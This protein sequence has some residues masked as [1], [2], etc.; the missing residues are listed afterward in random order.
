MINA[1]D[2]DT[3]SKHALTALAAHL[4]GP[5]PMVSAFCPNGYKH[6]VTIDEWHRTLRPAGFKLRN[7]NAFGSIGLHNPSRNATI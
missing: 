3:G 2:T 6:T 5:V 1:P 4:F 7:D